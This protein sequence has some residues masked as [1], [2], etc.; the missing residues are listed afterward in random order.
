MDILGVGIPEIIVILALAMM[1]FGPRRL[2]EI[3]R[4]IG[5]YVARLQRMASQVRSEWQDEIS[6]LQEIKRDITGETEKLTQLMPPTPTTITKEI[7]EQVKNTISMT[8]P[9]TATP[10]IS[11]ADAPKEI[12]TNE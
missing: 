3:A 4:Q 10:T 1:V 2:P 9:A 12:A 6:T 5:R 8:K 7:K 11:N